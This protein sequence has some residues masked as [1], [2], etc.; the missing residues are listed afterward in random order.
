ML[1]VKA[2]Q[3]AADLGRLVALEPKTK[4]SK[5][6]LGAALLV[7]AVLLAALGS[8]AALA[9]ISVGM[10][11]VAAALITRAATSPGQR[12]AAV[13]ALAGLALVMFGMAATPLFYL[14][15]AL[16][17]SGLIAAAGLVAVSRRGAR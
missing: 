4:H 11:L 3:T 10:F 17:G 13:I 9:A 5:A 8:F 2:G 12:V 1:K 14:G 7:G 16:I 6:L 15:W